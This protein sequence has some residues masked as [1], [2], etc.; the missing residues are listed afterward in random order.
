VSEDDAGA[1]SIDPVP[2][3]PQGEAEDDEYTDAAKRDLEASR[4]FRKRM[5]AKVA[6]FNAW[7]LDRAKSASSSCPP[8]DADVEADTAR[9]AQLRLEVE[10]LRAKASGPNVF[11]CKDT[12]HLPRAAA[13]DAELS[14]PPLRAL[15]DWMDDVWV[16]SIGISKNHG[17]TPRG[18]ASPQNNRN[19]GHPKRPPLPR[20]NP[21]SPTKKEMARLAEE[22]AMQ[23]NEGRHK[24]LSPRLKLGQNSPKKSPEKSMHLL[25]GSR[26]LHES[27][28]SANAIEVPNSA[29]IVEDQLDELLKELDEID[30][31]H[32]DVC[33]LA[34]P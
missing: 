3:H 22:K 6:S 25:S 4:E 26:N 19:A 18:I 11:R 10:N 31:I 1:N 30:R 20:S 9:V 12:G 33:M 28:T 32:D 8:R 34:K 27:T 16:S 15:H 7:E 5:E 17:H 14:E 21:S 23:W 13:I 2:E 24:G 29:S